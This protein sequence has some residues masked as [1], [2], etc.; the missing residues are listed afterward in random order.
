MIGFAAIV[1]GFLLLV[2]EHG[3]TGIVVGA[4]LVAALVL[5]MPRK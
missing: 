2:A 5:A 3:A 1:L 4:A